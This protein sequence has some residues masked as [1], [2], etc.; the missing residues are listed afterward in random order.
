MVRYFDGQE[1]SVSISDFIQSLELASEFGGWN[2][3]Q[4]LAV[5]KSRIIGP[6]L[7][8]LSGCRDV[9]TIS[10]SNLKQKFEEWFR[11]DIP[12]VDPL[13]T[14]YQCRQRPGEN[15]KTFVARLRAL[16]VAAAPDY[17]SPEDKNIRLALVDQS[18]VS[19]FT[20]G[21][22]RA[23]GSSQ[24]GML[25]PQNLNEALQLAVMYE[26][27]VKGHGNRVSIL[28]NHS[29]EVQSDSDSEISPSAQNVRQ[30]TQCPD[31][32]HTSTEDEADSRPAGTPRK[33]RVSVMGKGKSEEE[34]PRIQGML[35]AL[36]KQIASFGEA[37][38]QQ[39]QVARLMQRFEPPR[40]QYQPRNQF[41]QVANNN[42]ARIT[43]YRCREVGHYATNCPAA[44]KLYCDYC[45]RVGHTTSECRTKPR[46]FTPAHGHSTGNAR[47]GRYSPRPVPRENAPRENKT[48][49]DFQRS[50]GVEQRR[51][52]QQ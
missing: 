49:Q 31:H 25:K 17:M 29:M 12:L 10:Y 43:C 16:A 8:F 9:K 52:E 19:I 33:Q 2:E 21:L 42:N 39:T 22:T 24:V 7:I 50:S 34:M 13:A 27:S 44:M 26:D 5:F 6:A 41:G 18:I 14:F 1:G 37:V 15:A 20:K 35:S 11:E 46:E 48:P 38:Q 28:S 32:S 40:Q 3:Q 51:P 36:A 45:R 30:C 47:G 4:K 23:S